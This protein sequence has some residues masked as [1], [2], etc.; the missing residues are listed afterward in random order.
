MRR[1]LIAGLALTL[2]VN[3]HGAEDQSTESSEVGLVQQPATATSSHPPGLEAPY[4]PGAGNHLPPS[5]T[6][7]APTNT[8]TFDTCPLEKPARPDWQDLVEAK[9]ALKQ[10]ANAHSSSV[11]TAVPTASPVQVKKQAAFYQYVS[12]IQ[13]QLDALPPDQREAA[14]AE[15]KRQFMSE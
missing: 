7:V 15:I 13:P 5:H 4:P 10:D 8:T 9:E 14:Y 1:I 12:T 6:E 3:C 2:V 11:A